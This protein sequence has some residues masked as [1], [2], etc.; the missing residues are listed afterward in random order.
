MVGRY[1]LRAGCGAT[2]PYGM[3]VAGKPPP[4]LSVVPLPPLLPLP[5]LLPLPPPPPTLFFPVPVHALV[6]IIACG[7]WDARAHGAHA[8]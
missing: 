4:L 8:R 7:P 2:R 1:A 5:R 6:Q 3:R